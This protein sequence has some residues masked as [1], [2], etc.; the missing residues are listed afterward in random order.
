MPATWC[1]SYPADPARPGLRQMPL[2]CSS[3][4]ATAWPDTPRRDAARPGPADF[5]GTAGDELSFPATGCFRYV[6]THCFRY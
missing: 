1:F 2:S 6:G 4:P 5:P 3:Y